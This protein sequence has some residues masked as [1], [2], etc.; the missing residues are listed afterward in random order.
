MGRTKRICALVLSV[1]L[2]VLMGCGQAKEENVQQKAQP[3]TY[4]NAMKELQQQ[5]TEDTISCW[6]TSDSDKGYL[7]SAAAAFE[8]EYGIKVKLVYYDGVSLFEDM[9]QA[10]QKENGPEV[11]LMGNDQLEYAKTAG[12]VEQNTVFD[13]TFWKENYPDTAKKAMTYKDKQYGYPV[14]FDTYCLVYDAKLLE[15]APASIDD[16]LTFLDE[17]EDTGSTKA[18]F[19]WDV[20][21]PYVNSM[22]LASYA[23]LFGDNGDDMTSFQVNNEQCVAS[24]QYFQSLSAYLWMNKNNISHDTVMNRIKDGTLVLGLCKSDIL[25]TLYEMQS[26]QTEDSETD[27]RISYVPSLTAELSSTAWSTTYGA[28]VNSYG[29]DLAAGNMF[30]MYL[31]YAYQ[32]KQYSGN[33]KLPVKDQGEQFD[34]MQKV[35]YAQ[36][37]NSKPVPKVMILGDYLVES[38]IAFDAIWDGKDAQEELDWLQNAMTEKMQ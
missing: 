19:R 13:D 11:Y 3:V 37:L 18:V 22:F 20:A 6:Y 35:L 16:I 15:N 14:Y 1:L 12:V 4:E 5:V 23:D 28:F 29:K 26:T 30:A 36:Y 17:Y 34:D 10:N 38:G 31:S 21:D 2:C 8:K 24:M 27:Y 32:D 9:N 33:G 25:P 7:E